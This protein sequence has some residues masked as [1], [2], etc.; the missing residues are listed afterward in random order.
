MII[1][2]GPFDFDTADD[3]METGAMDTMAEFEDLVED[4]V[5]DSDDAYDGEGDN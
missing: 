5:F 4:Q 1:T 2:A 3:I